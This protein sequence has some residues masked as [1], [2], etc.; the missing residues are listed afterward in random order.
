MPEN[1]SK[2]LNHYREKS[3]IKTAAVDKYLLHKHNSSFGSRYISA[4]FS[5]VPQT[6]FQRLEYFTAPNVG[7]GHLFG[8]VA[9]WSEALRVS[10]DR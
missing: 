1:L 7:F 10:A 5:G 9:E 4:I 3:T 6:L 8:G 2:C